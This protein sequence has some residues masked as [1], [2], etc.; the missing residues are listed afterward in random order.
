M[1]TRR[2]FLSRSAA[3]GFGAAFSAP[4][5]QRAL[6]W[7][8]F[9]RADI[10]ALPA[11]ASLAG[12]D[13]TLGNT[14]IGGLWHVA[15]GRL[16]AIRVDDRVNRRTFDLPAPVFALRLDD[17]TLLSSDTM[18]VVG[19]P[20]L[21]S[22]RA[23]V[24]ASR[25]AERVGGRRVTVVL[26]DTARHLEAE[27]SAVLR[28]G[29][30]YLRQ[31]VTLRARGAEVPV[32]NITLVDLH[33]PG[34]VVTG[35]VKGSPVVFGDWYVGFEHPLSLSAVDGDHVTCALPRTLPLRPDAPVVVS[36]VIGAVRPGQLRR[37]FLAY[38]ERERA[39]PYRT[40]LH[41][42]SWYDIG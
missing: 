17:G 6:S 10:D 29:S 27:W 2:D 40:F 19:A 22:V 21:E 8:A 30:R 38:V 14:A 24:G 42:N 23:V 34:A 28:D 7:D 36:S 5:L 32:R 26:R 12:N 11:A 4:W 31:E 39:H 35:T 9:A 41:Y 15:D 16:R 37:D 18:T 20:R 3:L 25:Y 33:A 1:P 13:L